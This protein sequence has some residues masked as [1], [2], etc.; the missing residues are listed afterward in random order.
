MS[1]KQATDNEEAYK[2]KGRYGRW[3][4]INSTSPSPLFVLAFKGEKIG[5]RKSYVMDILSSVLGDGNSSYYQKKFVKSRRPLLNNVSV[6]NYTLKYNGVFFLMGELLRGV[7]INK[8]KNRLF[9]DFKNICDN[10]ITER[11]LQKTKNQY[12]QGYYRGI[13]TNAGIASFLG[14]RESYFND[15]EYYKKELSIYNSITVAELKS[16]CKQVF[17][18]KDYTLITSW[19]KHPKKK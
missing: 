1:F 13:Q 11:S 6:S 5:T 2:F 14:N 8:F 3:I 15:Y 19:N 17:K 9:K 7:N 4:K 10:A 12:F 18:D 16:T